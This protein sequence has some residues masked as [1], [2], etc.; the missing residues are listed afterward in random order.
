M[1]Q[2]VHQ[3]ETQNKGMQVASSNQKN[4][5]LALEKLLGSLRIPGYTL[6]VLKNE[7]LDDPDGVKECEGA[8]KKLM[9]IILSKSP[10]YFQAF[11]NLP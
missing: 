10:G 8:I 9:E 6:E 4:L 11:T 1:G 7:P 3:I 2:D 5:A